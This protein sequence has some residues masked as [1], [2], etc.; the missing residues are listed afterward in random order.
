MPILDTAEGEFALLS[1]IIHARPV[2]LQKHWAMIA[3]LRI[4][5]AKL[6]EGRV[7]S[8]QVWSKLHTLYDLRM[9]N[10]DVSFAFE[11]GV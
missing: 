2:G 6:G 8:D 4:I 10:E 7:T 1:A 11:Y 9:L 5:D 3:I